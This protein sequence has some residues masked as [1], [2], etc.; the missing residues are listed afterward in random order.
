MAGG[1]GSLAP[2]VK[3]ETRN[4]G[5]YTISGVAILIVAF[6]ILNRVFPDTVP[7]DGTVILGA[8]LGGAVAILNFFL[9]A[10]TVQKVTQTED[11]N[12]AQARMRLSY[13]YRTLMQMV[14][15]IIV[16]AAPCFYYIAGILPLFFPSLGIKLFAGRRRT[17]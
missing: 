17:S 9:M 3:K 5:I 10:V 12:R 8:L 16:L 11:E 7:F 2:A 13:T 1:L 14:W 4:V 6:A 15:V